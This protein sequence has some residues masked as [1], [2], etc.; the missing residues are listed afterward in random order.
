VH[1]VRKIAVSDWCPN[2]LNSLIGV[3]NLL[4]AFDPG[5]FSKILVI[6][7]LKMV[8]P[9]SQG[10]VAACTIEFIAIITTIPSSIAPHNQR[11]CPIFPTPSCPTLPG[12]PIVMIHLNHHPLL[13]LLC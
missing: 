5:N 10:G 9:I 1:L 3:K 2:L 6:D 11:L 4:N 12:Q 8:S 7:F 13:H